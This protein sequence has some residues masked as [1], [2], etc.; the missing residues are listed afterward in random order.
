LRT[1]KPCPAAEKPI[2]AQ[3]I[4]DVGKRDVDCALGCVAR[5]LIVEIAVVSM[6][7][8]KSL[9][10]WSSRQGCESCGV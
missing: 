3:L 1:F 8:E 6:I 5:D 9:L 7:G 4:N 2:L 10:H